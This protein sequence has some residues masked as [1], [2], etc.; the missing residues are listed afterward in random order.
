LLSTGVYVASFGNMLLRSRCCGIG[1]VA[2]VFVMRAV[3]KFTFR[4]LLEVLAVD[5]SAIDPV[6]NLVFHDEGGFELP[7][8]A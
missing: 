5:E 4:H 1:A 3:E 6:P 8:M 2:P 7:A